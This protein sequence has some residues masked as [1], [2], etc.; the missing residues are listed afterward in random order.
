MTSS[1]VDALFADRIPVLNAPMGGVAGGAL[2][3]AVSRAGGLGMIGM[4][5]SG[6]TTSLRRQLAAVTDG[7]EVG[8]GLVD[9]VVQRDPEM[10]ETALDA[11]PLLLSVSFGETYEWIGRAHERGVPAVAQVS[12]APT[13]ERALAAGADALVARG[14]EGGGHG[15]PL[16]DRDTLLDA[17]L[18]LTDR[19]V[20]AAGAIATAEDVRRV[21]GR[22]ARAAWVGTAFTACH[23]ALSSPG[24][25][26]ALL[27]AGPEDTVL[28]SAF[29]QASGYGWPSD[30]PERVIANDATRRW[31]AALD[32]GDVDV[33]GRELRAATEADDPS[34]MSVNAGLGVGE[35]RAERSAAEVVAALDP[36]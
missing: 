26:R 2:A 29:D 8:I 20:F 6:S 10:L 24:S 30:I 35:L 25:R 11:S 12:D 19:P 15:R 3:S 31:G 1:T 18:A 22:G 33:A 17:L 7:V 16:H 28:T 23:E 13:A 14:S 27:A 34:G 32:D 5:S 4:G 36:R 21:L 9:W